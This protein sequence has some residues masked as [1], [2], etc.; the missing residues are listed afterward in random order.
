MDGEAAAACR[1]A[2]SPEAAWPGVTWAPGHGAH[3]GGHPP[4]WRER[5]RDRAA[6]CCLPRPNPRLSHA[7]SRVFVSP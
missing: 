2:S 6:G 7:E 5:G 3:R 4:G 1:P